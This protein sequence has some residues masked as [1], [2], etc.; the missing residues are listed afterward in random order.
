MSETTDDD[1]NAA[2][3]AAER[4]DPDEAPAGPPLGFAGLSGRGLA[5]ACRLARRYPLLAC[6]PDPA[7]LSQFVDATAAALPAHTTPLLTE[8]TERCD[9]ILAA[10]ASDLA[11][12]A[13]TSRAGTTLLDLASADPAETR[14]LAAE[15][16]DRSIH[17]LDAVVLGTA[18]QIAD[19][20]AVVLAGGSGAVL[21]AVQSILAGLGTPVVA[22]PIGAGQTLALLLAARD[23]APDAA[24]EVRAVAQ[25]SGLDPA[26]LDAVGEAREDGPS[27]AAALAFAHAAGAERQVPT[28]LLT[29]AAQA[30]G[31]G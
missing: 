13:V 24:A 30:P 7:L 3:P 18:A 9:V 8:V 2:T 23:A 12:L 16:S 20:A 1:R 27:A 15:L 19:G 14:R 29:A 4:V 26:L 11:P 10:V 28:P 17:L 6:D 5:L 31:R 25:A 21:A 22:G